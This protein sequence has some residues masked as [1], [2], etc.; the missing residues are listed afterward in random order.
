MCIICIFCAVLICNER[1]IK[2]YCAACTFLIKKKKI[3]NNIR[4]FEEQKLRYEFIQLAFFELLYLKR[5]CYLR[6]FFK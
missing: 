3:E 1:Y 5:R 6:Y 4:F 2:Y